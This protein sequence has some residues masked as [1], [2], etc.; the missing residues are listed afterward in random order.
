[1]SVHA[2][3]HNRSL[4]L[5][6]KAHRC[7]AISLQVSCECIAKLKKTDLRRG[8]LKKIFPDEP[9]VLQ[10]EFRYSAPCIRERREVAP[11]PLRDGFSFFELPPKFLDDFSSRRSWCRSSSATPASPGFEAGFAIA[12]LL[13]VAYLVLRRRK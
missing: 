3:R 6:R 12:G 11:F 13:A 8:F 1:M 10:R 9:D 7:P 2:S 4:D 5:S